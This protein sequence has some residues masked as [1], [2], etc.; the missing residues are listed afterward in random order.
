MTTLFN[1]VHSSS[2]TPLGFV[3]DM[4]AVSSSELDSAGFLDA[5][6]DR[7]RLFLGSPAALEL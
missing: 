3:F 2:Y 5:D 1:S 7:D 4:P 6:E